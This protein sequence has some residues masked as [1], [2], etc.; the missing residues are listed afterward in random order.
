M[1]GPL[2]L[3][4]TPKP[5]SLNLNPPARLNPVAV[6]SE[7]WPDVVKYF[8]GFSH[9]AVGDVVLGFSL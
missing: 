2:I 7:Q 8:E 1:L 3:Q 6:G 4:V 5:Q 9:A